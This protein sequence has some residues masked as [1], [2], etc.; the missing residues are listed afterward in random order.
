MREETAGS[1]AALHAATAQ[2][3]ASVTEPWHRDKRAVLL[4]SITEVVNTMALL[5]SAQARQDAHPPVTIMIAQTKNHA[6][7]LLE[8]LNRSPPIA[9]TPL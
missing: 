9:S 8:L 6:G 1:V 7:V 5:K 3:Q 2:I 4:G